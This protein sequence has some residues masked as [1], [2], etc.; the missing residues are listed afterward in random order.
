M[1]KTQRIELEIDRGNI[2]FGDALLITY[3]HKP[4][5]T[6]LTEIFTRISYDII[7]K[8]RNIVISDGEAY[9]FIW[10]R[11]RSI[12]TAD[13]FE[14][15]APKLNRPEDIVFNR[16]VIALYH[17]FNKPSLAIEK[18]S[19]LL[20]SYDIDVTKLYGLMQ[21]F[22]YK[23]LVWAQNTVKKVVL[24]YY[25][26]KGYVTYSISTVPSLFRKKTAIDI[27]KPNIASYFL[28]HFNNA[29]TAKF[30]VRQGTE[31]VDHG[32]FII[33]IINGN[34]RHFNYYLQ[35]NELYFVEKFVAPAIINDALQKGFLKDM[36]LSGFICPFC[37]KDVP[38]VVFA[39]KDLIPFDDIIN[40]QLKIYSQQEGLVTLLKIYRE[41]G[42][43]FYMCPRCLEVYKCQKEKSHC[44][45]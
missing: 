11:F 24:K 17:V 30:E 32:D 34:I 23:D 22:K 42:S 43:G 6:M 7:S 31:I 16:M 4:Q 18:Y 33:Q 10:N 44:Q 38:Q 14:E 28:L 26:F 29:R 27:Y 41:A 21:G 15:I 25:K 9:A 1:M 8:R 5:H 12:L 2:N 39:N 20:L 45:T 37:K 40:Q 13:A 3:L 35:K 19:N 36:A